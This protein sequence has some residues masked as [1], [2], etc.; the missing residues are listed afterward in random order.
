MYDVKD[1]ND[2]TQAAFYGIL[3]QTF[4]VGS[5]AVSRC[6]LGLFL[7]RIVEQKLYRMAVWGVLGLLGVISVLWVFL[8]WLQCVPFAYLYDRTIPGGKCA[9]PLLGASV[10]HACKLSQS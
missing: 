5:V 3:S 1:M 10:L 6:S 4:A 7:L 9:I 8:F 2:I